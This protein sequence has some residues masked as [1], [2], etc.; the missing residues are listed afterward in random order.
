MNP[1]HTYSGAGNYKVMLTASNAAGNN[2]VTKANYI[3]ALQ[4]PVAN[5]WGS[6]RS[7]NVPLNVT[8]TDTTTGSPTAWNWSFGDGTYSTYMNPSHTYNKEGGY[9]VSLTAKNAAGNNTAT[10][11]KYIVVNV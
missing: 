7:G 1:S 6:S 10:K 8:F 4:K 3:T 9:T 5:F 11:F 2:V